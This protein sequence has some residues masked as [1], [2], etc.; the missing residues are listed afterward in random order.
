MSN[1]KDTHVAKER[2]DKNSNTDHLP[3]FESKNSST[4]YY[5]N[6]TITT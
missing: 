6:N 5:W 1:T 4:K 3:F 2:P